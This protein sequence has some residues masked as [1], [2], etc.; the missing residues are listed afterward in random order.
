MADKIFY[1]SLRDGGL[2]YTK[3]LLMYLGVR[4]GGW[5]AWKNS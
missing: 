4:I 5:V 3:A 1:Y 2:R